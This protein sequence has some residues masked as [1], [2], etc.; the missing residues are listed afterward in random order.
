MELE[1]YFTAF[2][3]NTVNLK[4]WKLNQLD[5]RV[6]A[7]VDALKKDT[8]VG[9]LYQDHIPQGSWAH[10]TIIT[11]VGTLDEFDADFL[12]HI[13]EVPEWSENPR[14]YLREVRAAFKR[15][16]TYQSKL[17]RKNRCVR[18]D[19]ANDCHVD[20]VPYLVRDDG[21]QVIVNYKDNK[22]EDTNPAGFTSWMKEK[23]DI[24]NG[25]LRRVI[26]L[27]KYIR[28]YK[29]TFDCPSVILTTL[30]GGRV[31]AFDTGARY[32]SIGST[33][34]ALLE[35]LDSWLR[36]HEQMPVLEDPS[37]L[38]TY[39]N[40]RWTQEK[41]ANF[42]VQVQRYA[43]WAREALVEED[44]D[45]SASLWRKLFGDTFIAEENVRLAKSLAH[46]R[47]DKALVL[48]APDE[49]FIHEHYAYV[50]GYSARIDAFVLRDS[51][52][53]ARSLRVDGRVEKSRNLL[54]RVV[55]DVPG[56]FDVIWK[57]RNTGE[58]A[59]RVG[60]LRGQLLEGD[61]TQS[62]E[63]RESTSYAG[64][65][66]VEVYIL[67]GGRVVASDHHAVVIR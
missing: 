20:V 9:A 3:E 30:L 10:E 1:N 29:N 55:T 27:L 19:Y 17:Q 13:E 64:N 52:R 24:T 26:R 62:V 49:E 7:I 35:D 39:F 41:Y 38:G 21:S 31:Q 8:V 6:N 16:T 66:F 57:V 14:E 67:K 5:G 25:N 59:E 4:Q 65:H 2:L 60:Q 22:F 40:H 44:E 51:G 32:A 47:Q 53:V 33:L 48:R 15:N 46:S 43:E 28:D 37:C 50:G 12:L 54:F 61:G 18:I 23:D 58:E 56:E 45:T 63:H 11:P 42:R 36:W 34:V